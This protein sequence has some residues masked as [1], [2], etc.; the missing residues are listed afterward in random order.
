MSAHT[1]S[2]FIETLMF[3]M[4]DRE[5]K[6]TYI[7]YFK[8]PAQ[9]L[10][11]NQTFKYK[12]KYRRSPSHIST[13]ISSITESRFYWCNLYWLIDKDFIFQMLTE[14]NLMVLNLGSQILLFYLTLINLV[15]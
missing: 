14:S 15:T 5:R 11:L 9:I 1:C 10:F 8:S 4:R 12:I 2:I 7:Q 3:I 6:S 13:L